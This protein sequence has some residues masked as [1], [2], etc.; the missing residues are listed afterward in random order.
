[1]AE[2]ESSSSGVGPDTG[3]PNSAKMRRNQITSF[4][5]SSKLLISASAVESA[6]VRCWRDDHMMAAPYN[7]M[8]RPDVERRLESW[9][10]KSASAYP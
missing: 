7:M 10:A 3:V 5:N 2:R 6:T 1:M 4:P 8:T 9:F